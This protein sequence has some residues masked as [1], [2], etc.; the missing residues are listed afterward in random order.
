[1]LVSVL[2]LNTCNCP[3]SSSLTAKSIEFVSFVINAVLLKSFGNV[4]GITPWSF[5]FQ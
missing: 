3:V 2:L 5:S 1:M 4:T